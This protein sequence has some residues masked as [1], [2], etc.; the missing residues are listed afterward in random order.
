MG[1]DP[2]DVARRRARAHQGGGQGRVDAQ[3]ARGKLTARERLTRLLDEGTFQEVQTYLTHRFADFGMADR[4]FEGDSVVA[5]FG[6]IGGRMTAVYAQ[7]F[8][9]VGGTFSE[10]QAQKI[11]QV[12]ELAMESGVPV[13][14]LND[15]GGARIQEGVY[16]LAGYGD[17]FWQNTQAS[18][19]IPQISVMLGSCAGGSVYSP[20]LT[21][22]V[23]MT[24][25]L[26]HM[27][28]TGPE[29]IR[30][31]TRE[32][33]D[34]E[35]L[36]G[37]QVH[38]ARSGVAHFVGGDEAES[39]RLVQRLL[40]YL[41][42]NNA[43]PPP[44]I[45]PTDDPWRMDADLNTIVPTD[46]AQAYD[47]REVIRRVF[48]LE[49]F[50]E[51]HQ[52]FARNALVGFARLHGAPVGVV[53]QQPQVLAGVIDIDAADKMARFI[54]FCD[55]FNL[56]IVTL[57]DSPGFMPGVAQEH[58]GIIRHGA[59]IVY[60][61]S[62]ATVPLLTLVLRKAYGGAYIVMASKHIRADLT[63]AWPTAEIAVMGV[64]GAVQIVHGRDLVSIDDPEERDRQ[65]RAYYGQ[66]R[67]KFNDPYV[68]AR[69]GHVDD[70][71]VPSETRPRLIGAL[72]LLRTKR[73]R[74]PSRK[75]GNM[76]L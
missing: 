62:E 33:V 27:F 52:D 19:V 48:D 40:S 6:K 66:F 12:M 41:P 45:E 59:K 28:I 34:L 56:P 65:M 50:L 39:L 32:E 73:A 76:P 9:V 71:L 3:H 46:P 53:A 30:T 42:S 20:A 17:L 23:I 49:S 4:R 13:V 16:S 8:T 11:C 5:G 51:V 75:H 55:A 43:E 2:A 26:S 64:E 37:A 25:G 10:A 57:V 58:G 47:M 18:G 36:G 54:R 1:H 22:F 67:E 60:A 72:E 63:F 31:V 35:G 21:D 7:D 61:Y 38:S 15:S 44:T 29:V 14:G 69:S 74:R 70:V 24:R 68:V